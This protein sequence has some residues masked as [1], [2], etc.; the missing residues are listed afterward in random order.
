MMYSNILSVA[1]SSYKQSSN[2]WNK[3]KKKKERRYDIIFYAR[4]YIII[5]DHD[6]FPENK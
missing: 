1:A 4:V 2:E 5:K 6:Q 3:T